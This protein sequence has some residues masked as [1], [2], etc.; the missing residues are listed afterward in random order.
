MYLTIVVQPY[1]GCA[2]FSTRVPYGRVRGSERSALS[3]VCDAMAVQQSCTTAVV[4]R[5]DLQMHMY[6]RTTAVLN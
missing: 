4:H 3:L 2:K 1:R 6:S 5:V